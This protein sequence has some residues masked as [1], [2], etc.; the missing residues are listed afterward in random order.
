MRHWPSMACSRLCQ[1]FLHIPMC[2]L[3]DSRN[4][5]QLACERALLMTTCCLNTGRYACMALPLPPG[6]DS[7]RGMLWSRERSP[8]LRIKVMPGKERHQSM[9]WNRGRQDR[10]TSTLC[11]KSGCCLQRQWS[12]LSPRCR[13]RKT[14]DSRELHLRRCQTAQAQCIAGI[15]PCA[16]TADVRTLADS[17]HTVKQKVT[18]LSLS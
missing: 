8:I 3:R 7:L 17:K 13:R 16:G 6:K 5:H 18:S 9:L 11:G 14:S 4:A 1:K 2:C 12:S 10:R 15:Y